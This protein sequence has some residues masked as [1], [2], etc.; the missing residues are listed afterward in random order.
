M[1]GKDDPEKSYTVAVMN[2]SGERAITLNN[3]L[4]SLYD[5]NPSQPSAVWISYVGFSDFTVN[6]SGIELKTGFTE[7]TATSAVNND[8][9]GINVWMVN[10]TS[11][12]LHIFSGT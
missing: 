1:L 6:V 4:D 10:D 8:H 2:L 11:N 9:S 12:T 7:E 5:Y 3:D